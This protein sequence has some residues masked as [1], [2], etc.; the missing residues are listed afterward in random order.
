MHEALEDYARALALEP[1]FRLARFHQAT[2]RLMIGDFEGGWP[3][4]ELRRD[5]S[6]F[7]ARSWNLPEWDG[8]TLSGRAL[9][10]YGEQG[11]GDEIMFASLYPEV[12]AVARK[13]VLE[14]H[15]KLL[16]L[17]A[18]SFPGASVSAYPPDTSSPPAPTVADLDW[19]SPS[20]SLPRFLRP[21]RE[22]FPAHSGYLKADPG[23]VAY[24]KERLTRLGDGLKV[25][26][27][28]SGGVHRTRQPVRSLPL[29]EWGPILKVPGV[30]FISLQ[31]TESASQEAGEASGRHGVAIAHWPE[32]IEDYDETAALVCALDLVISVCTA[33]IHLGGA[34]GRPVWVMTPYSPEWRYGFTGQGMVWY[35]TVRLF[36]QPAYGQW[37]AVVTS[38]AAGLR[39]LA[40]PTGAE[41]TRG[42]GAG[43]DP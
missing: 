26:I 18:R 37:D 17:F 16:A 7:K 1:D 33:V 15:P 39:A 24:W 25:G 2:A 34:L 13:C 20:G 21:N 8:S 9:R 31:Y 12:I 32:A 28:W 4:Y 38:V 29:G 5:S 3:G 23:R 27:S 36:R 35:P 42:A 30:R 11:L 6:E 10:I 22:A 41:K 14:C 43:G 40:G 19:E